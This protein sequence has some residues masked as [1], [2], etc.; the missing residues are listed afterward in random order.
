MEGSFIPAA[1]PEVVVPSCSSFRSTRRTPIAV[2]LVALAASAAGLSA[3]ETDG[4]T[5]D[6][7]SGRDAL[8]A[9][10]AARLRG[11]ADR[12]VE[13]KLDDAA[14][15]TRD[16]VIPRD[17]RRQYHLPACRDGPRQDCRRTLR[18]SSSSG[19]TNSPRTAASRR[20][21]CS[22]WL[23]ANCRQGAR[24]G[25]FSCCTKCCTRTPTTNRSAGRSA[26][27]WSTAAGGSRS[28]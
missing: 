22:S 10:Y 28:P 21:P 14:Q 16:W 19:T 24:R 11:L 2:L 17:P 8:D 13:L 7:W 27:G 6:Y 1:S 12:C 18:R 5:D 25:H 9:A 26:T 23:A 4:G 15:A 20:R 3:A